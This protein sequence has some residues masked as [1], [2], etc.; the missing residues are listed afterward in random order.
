MSLSLYNVLTLDI[1]WNTFLQPNL[2]FLSNWIYFKFGLPFS[3]IGLFLHE[4]G[5]FISRTLSNV[6]KLLRIV[7]S[8]LAQTQGLIQSITFWHLKIFFP[9]NFLN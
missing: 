7:L 3:I 5:H 6:P 2:P 8:G 1:V 9:N 4:I